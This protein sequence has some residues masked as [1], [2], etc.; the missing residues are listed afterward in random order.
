MFKLL[1]VVL[2]RFQKCWGAQK[3]N[4]LYDMCTCT[5]LVTRNWSQNH[6]TK[7]KHTKSLKKQTLKQTISTWKIMCTRVLLVDFLP[8]DIKIKCCIL[9]WYHDKIMSHNP[10]Q[11]AW[12]VQSQ[13]CVAARQCLAT[14]LL[15]K[16]KSSSNCLVRN[17]WIP[18]P[19][20]PDL[21]PSDF[22]LFL[23][24]KQCLTSQHYDV[25]KNVKRAVQLGFAGGFIP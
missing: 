12:Y 10:Q 14:R 18:P 23:Y 11:K 8:W 17:K 19:H 22:H 13:N 20:N 15:F 24:L 16:L 4:I 6:F 21:M 1:E 2:T 25:D 9:L 5:P 7:W 3:T